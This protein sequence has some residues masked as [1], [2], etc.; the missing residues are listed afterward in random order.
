MHYKEA[1]GILSSSNGMNIYRGCQHGCVYCDSRSTCYHIEHEFEDIEVK[2]NAVEL[3]ETALSKKRNKCMIGTGS[4]TD[5]YIPLEKELRY[6]RQCLE[7]IERHGFGLAI[8]TK[9]DLILRD[10]DLLKKINTKSKCIVQITLTTADDDLCRKLEPGVC[11]TSRRVEV[12]DILRR[13]KIPTVVWLS[14]ILP[15]INDTEENI[16]ALMD[17]IVQVNVRG[18][19]FF[20]IGMTLREGSRDYFYTQ[21][22]RLFPG[23]KER[24]RNKYGNAYQIVSDHNRELSKI[25]FD[26]CH[27]HEILCNPDQVF[28]WMRTFEDKDIEIQGELF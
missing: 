16:R 2:S 18:I 7:A 9:S 22:D 4:M 28:T 8:L 14:P 10:L 12:L 19:V 27:E 5:P 1:K 20:G 25:V 21:L 6:T 24:Y 17:S 15:F 26:A 23:M 3:L 13:E 11:P